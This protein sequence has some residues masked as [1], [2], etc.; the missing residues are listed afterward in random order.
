LY[1]KGQVIK[2]RVS[3]KNKTAGSPRTSERELSEIKRKNKWP[4]NE[5]NIMDDGEINDVDGRHGIRK[6]QIKV[7]RPKKRFAGETGTEFSSDE[8][9]MAQ[10]S[11]ARSHKNK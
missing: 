5:E 10:F 9:L 3:G 4:R 7:I 8:E 2:L 6:V 1:I 11:T